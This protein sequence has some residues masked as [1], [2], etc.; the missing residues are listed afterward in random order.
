MCSLVKNAVK[1]KAYEWVITLY[2]IESDVL[3]YPCSNPSWT[4][5]AQRGTRSYV[6]VL[7]MQRPRHVVGISGGLK[8]IMLS[9]HTMPLS[10]K[11]TDIYKTLSCHTA[12]LI[13]CN[14][15]VWC[16][17]DRYVRVGKRPDIYCNMAEIY[18]QV[19]LVIVFTYLTKTDQ[20]WCSCG[21]HA[22]HKQSQ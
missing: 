14:D 18:W 21:R 22:R 11:Y 1:M 5:L 13:K 15:F 6:F 12:H 3:E 20:T 8:A 17:M 7:I 2:Q 4:I 9:A 16:V 10:M 19:I